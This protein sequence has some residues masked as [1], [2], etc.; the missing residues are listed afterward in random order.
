MTDSNKATIIYELLLNID[1]G[2]Y[3]RFTYLW[4]DKYIG[5]YHSIIN[6]EYSGWI[7]S[8]KNHLDITIDIMAT[9]VPD[10]EYTLSVFLKIEELE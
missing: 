7:E 1:T 6:D 9:H 3:N 2:K 8:I 5:R 10:A 4:V